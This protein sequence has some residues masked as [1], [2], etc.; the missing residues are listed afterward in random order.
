MLWERFARGALAV[1]G[2]DSRRFSRSLLGGDLVLDRRGLELLEPQLQLI[3][4]T[5]SP[6]GTRSIDLAPQLLDLQLQMRDQGLVVGGLGL[7]GSDIGL[8][9]DASI[10]LGKQRD[11]QRLDIVGK[12]MEGER[13]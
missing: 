4:K 12:V 8:G 1:E 9:D 2:G 11:L 6:F 5:R 10:A 3:E 7:D 13:P